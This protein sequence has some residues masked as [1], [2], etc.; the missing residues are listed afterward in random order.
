MNNDI[1]SDLAD[2]FELNGLG[3][4]G[5]DIFIG[6]LP[7]ET[8]GIYLERAGG[9]LN[10]YLPIEETYINVYVQNTS[11]QTAIQT[12]ENI[13][14]TFHRHLETSSGNSFIYTIL[15]LSDIEDLARDINFGKIYKLTLVVTHR[16]TAL[17][18]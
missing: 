9:A 12:I 10:N 4:V 7:A 6:S 3:T 18:S 5:T 1:L 14:R 16:N 15:A 17:I 8:N 11:S 13:K 2:I